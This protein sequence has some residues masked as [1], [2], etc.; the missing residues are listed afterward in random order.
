LKKIKD[1]IKNFFR[2][3]FYK[4]INFI[5]K[6]KNYLIIFR[7]GNA[8]GDHICLTGVIAKLYKD[9]LKII[10]LS[11][12]ID[13]FKNN[14]KIYKIFDLNKFFNKFFLLKILALFEGERIKSYRS[15]I[16]DTEK[17]FFMKY[18]L[19]DIHFGLT[20]ADH[21]NFEMKNQVFENEI[22]FSEIEIET[23]E[24]KFNLPKNFSV[25]HSQAKQSL[26]SNKNWGTKRIQN[27]V[28]NISQ[29]KW[30]QVGK[31]GEHELENTYR[32]YLDISLRELAFIIFKS[33][34]IVSMEGM[35]NHLASAFKKKNFLV[36]MGFMKME[37]IY[38]PNNILIHKNFDLKCYPCFLF[39][40]PEHSKLCEEKLTSEYA[41]KIIQNELK[42][43]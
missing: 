28:N 43:N 30:I 4:K 15:K 8:I 35:F 36:H 5:L 12:Y 19:K 21:F 34:F 40:C 25:I 2:F 42:V 32:K 39:E 14:P 37:T 41:V 13:F 3:L 18:I 22:Y 20:H 23:Y 11:N 38:Y 27:V 26:T 7:Y 10:I 17:E 6:K 31:Y 1:I 9:D 33:D 24:K 29:I 16:E